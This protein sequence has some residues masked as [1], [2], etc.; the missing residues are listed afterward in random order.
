VDGFLSKLSTLFVMVGCY[1]ITEKSGKHFLV[2][3]TK[4]HTRTEQVADKALLKNPGVGRRSPTGN[5]IDTLCF[6]S[7]TLNDGY[8]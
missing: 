4:F 8:P 5:A 3:R 7:R 1:L 2:M 6:I